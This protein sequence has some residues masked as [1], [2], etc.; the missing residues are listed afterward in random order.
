M[1]KISAYDQ[2]LDVAA[3]CIQKVGFNAF[4]Y[5]DIAEKIGIRKASIHYHFPSKTD[6]GKALMVRHRENTVAYLAE[7]M[8]KDH[9]AKAVLVLYLKSIFASTYESNYKMC[10]GGMLAADILTLDSSIQNEVKAFFQVNEEWLKQLLIQGK[11]E[12]YFDFINAPLDIARQILTIIEGSL[13]LARLY[14]DDKWL[15]TAMK[16][17]IELVS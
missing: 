7:L 6:L 17:V 5:A 10:L 13:L 1:K 8:I 2:I 9:D 16:Q 3:E 4:S 12:G 11:K 14:Q 15:K